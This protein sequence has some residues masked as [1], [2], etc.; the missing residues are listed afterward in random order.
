MENLDSRQSSCQFGLYYK[1]R[2]TFGLWKQS[3]H[4]HTILDF[5]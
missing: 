5:Y 1:I 4:V 3:V 2:H